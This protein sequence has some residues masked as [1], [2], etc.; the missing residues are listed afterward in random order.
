VKLSGIKK[1]VAERI[2]AS[3][4]DAPHIELT[5]SVDMGPA[6]N[7]R[8]RANLSLSTH[9]TFSDILIWTV[10]RTLAKGHRLLNAG[11]REDS[12]YFHPE[13]NIGLASESEKGL[14]V[15]VIR[16]ADHLSL[17]EIAVERKALTDRVKAGKQ[18]ME[19]V[20]DGSFTITNLGMYGIE[21]FNPILTPGQSAILA[22]GKIQNTPVADDQGRIFVAPMTSMTLACDHRVVDGADGAK[23]LADLKILLEDRDVLSKCLSD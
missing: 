15:P 11:F 20:S 1:T 9:V 6:S 10:A 13:I 22:V 3:Y 18:S 2:K 16:K 23:F 21:S 8:D 19:D 4:L 7:L 17:S 14:V 12:I 5:L